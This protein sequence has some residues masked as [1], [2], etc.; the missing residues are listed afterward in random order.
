MAAWRVMGFGIDTDSVVS[1]MFSCG[2]LP[3]AVFNLAVKRREV[4]MYF[5]EPVIATVRPTGGFN[6]LQFGGALQ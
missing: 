2:G 3:A 1:V 6:P 4:Q 5:S